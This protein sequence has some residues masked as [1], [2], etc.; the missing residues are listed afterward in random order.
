MAKTKLAVK[1]QRTAQE[2]ARFEKVGLKPDFEPDRIILNWI[3]A[4]VI[5]LDVTGAVTS[6]AVTMSIEE[7]PTVTMTLRDPDGRLFRPGTHRWDPADDLKSRK[8]IVGVDQGWR[9]VNAPD[10][11]LRALDMNLDGV[12]FRLV[13][14]AWTQS[15]REWNLTFEHRLV[16]WL[17]ERRGARRMSRDKV[18]RAE[19]VLALLREVP[20]LRGRYRFVCPELHV[21]QPMALPKESDGSA[22]TGG[23][24]ETGGF[25][26]EA[27]IKVKGV[28]ATPTQRRLLHNILTEATRLGATREVRIATVMCATQESTIR[29][30][31][32]GDRVRNDTIGVFQQGP[33]WISPRN[34][35]NVKKATRAFLK[36]HEANVGGTGRVQG[37][38]QKHGSLA[39]VPGGYEAAIKKVQVSIGG[40]A[41]WQHEA[42]RTVDK[43]GGPGRLKPGESFKS[44]HPKQFQFS[45]NGDEDTWTAMQRLGDEV[46]WRRF[47]V[48]N[49]LYFMAEADLY[50]RRVRYGL[51]DDDAALLELTY[52]VDWGKAVAKATA[53]VQLDRWGAPPGSV[54][55]LHGFGPADGR[56]LVSSVSRDWFKPVADIELR[57]PIT[58]RPEPASQVESDSVKRNSPTPDDPRHGS[59]QDRAQ[60][61]AKK[62]HDMQLPYV[63]G[64]GHRRAGHP[65]G[66]TGR[67]PGTGFDCSGS[68]SAF[69]KFLGLG[70]DNPVAG[71]GNMPGLP[72][73]RPGRGDVFTVWYNSGHVYVNFEF[74]WRWDRLDTSGAG[75][76]GPR[77]R[78]GDRIGG[79]FNPLHWKGW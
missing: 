18:T 79:G 44:K 23:D 7:A 24:T 17:R 19:F 65:D 2:W 15:T 33:E 72:G 73:A 30:T 28:E 70:G 26:P 54:V 21:K 11:R 5:D 62:V 42:T 39:R 74:D 77:L 51:T 31:P 29:M 50:T 4:R 60:A 59:K 10:L 37:W 1:G 45:R 40:Y 46:G 27:S 67:D 53:Q 48:G 3:D 6:L 22:V 35:R 12:V 76:R 64:G 69:L 63:W 75:E 47:V 14:V 78:T 55:E 56:W 57:S 66:G 16:A 8:R 34:T 41:Q 49:S 9:P 32:H 43:W 68:T 13:K 52:E 20:M 25:S 58:E 36:G 71:S 38:K 61:S